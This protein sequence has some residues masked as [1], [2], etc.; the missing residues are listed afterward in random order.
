MSSRSLFAYS[1]LLLIQLQWQAI[2]VLEEGESFPGCFIDADGFRFN[3]ALI[4][5]FG[6]FCHIFHRET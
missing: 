4:Q 3:A 1:L 6:G 2:R 5:C